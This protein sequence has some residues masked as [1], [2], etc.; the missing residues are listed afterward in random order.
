M[1]V[2]VPHIIPSSTFTNTPTKNVTRYGTMSISEKKKTACTC[3]HSLKVHVGSGVVFRRK[4]AHLIMGNSLLD[5]HIG[6]SIS[7]SIVRTT[8]DMM[9]AANAALGM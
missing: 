2:N 6:N 5:F 1:C 7:T 4:K 3:V 8:D 9:T